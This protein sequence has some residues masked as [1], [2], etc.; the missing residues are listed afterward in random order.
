M[1]PAAQLCMIAGA[2]ACAI[3]SG[4]P[5]AGRDLYRRGTSCPSIVAETSPCF[6]PFPV[7]CPSHGALQMCLS[8]EVRHMVKIANAGDP[9]LVHRQLDEIDRSRAVL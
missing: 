5:C 1:I 3:A 6:R 8:R 4:A 2:D 7:F 9:V